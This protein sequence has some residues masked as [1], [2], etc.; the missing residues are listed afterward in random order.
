MKKSQVY[1]DEER[2]IF[3]QSLCDN[4]GKRGNPEW[5]KALR[6]IDSKLP[7]LPNGKNEQ[8]KKNYL[9]AFWKTNNPLKSRQFDTAKAIKKLEENLDRKNLIEMLKVKAQAFFLSGDY[10]NLKPSEKA[11]LVGDAI[12]MDAEEE[13]IELQ[14]AK[15]AANR[16]MMDNLS[17]ALMSGDHSAVLDKYK[18]EVNPSEETITLIGEV[19]TNVQKVSGTGVV[20]SPS[21]DQTIEII[22]SGAE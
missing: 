7:G 19:K 3:L 4:I 15:M 2:A 20:G 14:R 22:G 12:R 8:T 11:K 1:S 13:K 6:E 17:A 10:D 21:P 18:V 5:A 16:R 9:M